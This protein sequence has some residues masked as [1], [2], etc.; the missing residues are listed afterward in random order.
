MTVK[1]I[2]R[3]IVSRSCS[4]R[5]CRC[6]VSAR[7]AAR[8]RRSIRAPRCSSARRGRRSTPARRSAAAEAFRDALAADPRNARLHL[9]AGMA[10][11]LE[12]RDADARDEFE[13]ALA[14]D[15]KLT[16]ARALLGQIQY[17]MGDALRAIRTYETLVADVARRRERAGD[18]R[19]LAARS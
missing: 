14:L 10:A 18:A 19:A 11:A 3:M 8:A 6:A 9:G 5:C 4:S 1:Q 12:R 13:R 17:R 7:A 16:Q 15:P 2:S